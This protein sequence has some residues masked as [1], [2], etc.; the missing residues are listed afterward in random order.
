MH[1]SIQQRTTRRVLVRATAD[2]SIEL[3]DRETSLPLV[4]EVPGRREVWSGATPRRLRGPTRRVWTLRFAFVGAAA[5]VAA[6]VVLGLTLDLRQLGYPGVLLASFA[7]GASMFIPLPGLAVIMAASLVLQPWAVG[8][9][10]GVGGGLGEITGYALGCSS[11]RVL[12]SQGVPDWLYR[13][14]RNHM[15]LTIIGVSIIPNPFIDFVG[16]IAGR[17]CYPVRSFLVYSVLGKT[18][19]ASLIAYGAAWGLPLMSSW[20]GWTT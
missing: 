12:K 6:L 1:L 10:A 20:V 4:G 18:V 14:A 8:V 13:A 11:H 5:L 15:A 7:S 16:I 19:R 2:R 3:E 9:L 17:M